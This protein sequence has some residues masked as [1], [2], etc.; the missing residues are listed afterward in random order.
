MLKAVNILGIRGVPAAHGGFETFAHHLAPYLAKTGWRVTVYCQHDNADSDAPSDGFE[1][2]WEGVHRVHFRVRGDGPSSTIKFDMRCARD[3]LKRPG[4]DL[5][6]G[7]NTAIFALAQRLFGRKIA[8]NMD[9]V[10]W[11]RDKW[12]ILA[13]IWFY[14]N[15]FA[16]SHLATVPIADHPE[17]A[18]HLR[19]HGCRRAT[20]IPYGAARIEETDLAPLSQW[21]I[22]PQNYLVS[23]ARIEP[24]NSILEIVKSF[25]L[26]PRRIKLVVLGSFKSDNDYHMTVKAAASSDV[27]FPGAIYD[28]RVVE[29]LRKNALAYLHG[30]QV[31]G[32]NPSLVE[33]LAAG[34]A[35]IAHNNRFNRWV[36]GKGQFY[37]DND[38]DL[39][40][41]IEEADNGTLQVKLA[42]EMALQRHR[43]EFTFDLVHKKYGMLLDSLV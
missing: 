15:E 24:E 28:K 12:T 2:V 9:G 36:A 32:T 19:R 40:A 10:E 4:V 21:N 13:K 35:V 25:S 8:I 16:G 26:T 30:H 11:R 5:I 20:V 18:L 23:I 6:L 3:V 38:V 37:F 42:G 22:S 1:D 7:Y 34:N 39:A 33:S 29:S 17:I 43:E 27:I 31:G 41:I 14:L